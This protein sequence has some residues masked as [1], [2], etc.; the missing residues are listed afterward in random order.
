MDSLLLFPKLGLVAG[1]TLG[2]LVTS[3]LRG[4]N[5]APTVTEHV[6]LMAFRTM[7]TNMT[8]KQLQTIMPPFVDAYTK[9]CKAKSLTPDV[10]DIPGTSTKG[11]WLGDKNKATHVMVYFHGGGFVMPGIPVSHYWRRCLAFFHASQALHCLS[12]QNTDVILQA[13]T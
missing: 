7:F 2:A 12:L 13:T 8:Y 9:W 6:M 5:G 10:V 11:F 4:E 1:K 3:P